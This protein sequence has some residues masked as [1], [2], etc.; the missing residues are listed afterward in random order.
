MVKIHIKENI[1]ILI[2]LEVLLNSQMIG[3]IFIKTLKNTAQ[4]NNVKY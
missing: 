3:M 2:I 1:S 4:I